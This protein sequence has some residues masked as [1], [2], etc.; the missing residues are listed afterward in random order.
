M[1]YSSTHVYVLESMGIGIGIGS[2]SGV[3]DFFSI[4]KLAH[5]PKT[6]LCLHHSIGTGAGY[7]LLSLLYFSFFTDYFWS[8]ASIH[9]DWELQEACFLCQTAPKQTWTG[10]RCD[11]L[12]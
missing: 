12:A 9:L 1:Y 8:V 3:L 10:T 5:L 2:G 7:I 11:S 4:H 6:S